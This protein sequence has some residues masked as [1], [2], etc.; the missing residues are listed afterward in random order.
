MLNMCLSF[1]LKQSFDLFVTKALSPEESQLLRRVDIEL[2][3]ESP[4]EKVKLCTELLYF[5]TCVDCT[6]T[7]N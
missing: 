1:L 4:L 7:G 6:L 3:L 5:L 2:N